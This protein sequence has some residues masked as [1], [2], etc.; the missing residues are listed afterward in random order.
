MA[1]ARQAAAAALL[2]AVLVVPAAGQAPQKQPAVAQAVAWDYHVLQVD[3]WDPKLVARI[4]QASGPEVDLF[5][6]Y[7]APP[8]LRDHDLRAAVPGMPLESLTVDA[9]SIPPLRSGSWWLGVRRA[10]VVSYQLDFHVETTPSS[11]SGMGADPHA[12]GTSFRVWAPFATAV[13]LAGDFNNWSPS[14]APMASEGNGNWSLDVRSVA[15]GARYKYVIEGPAGALWRNDPRA[16]QLTSSSG[17]SVVV[18]PAAFVW[19]QGSYQTPAWNDM[20]VYEMHLGTFRDLPGPA[21]GTLDS[22]RQ[23]LPYLQDLGVNVVELM[24]LVEF[25]GDSSWGYNGSH[26]FAVESAYGDPAALKR[27]VREAHARGI[28]VVL[29][30][31]WNHW[32]PLEMDLWRFDGWSQGP[33]GGIYFYNDWRAQTPWGDT[34]PDFGRGEVR[35]YIRDNALF[36]LQEYRLD[37]L[38]VDST[39]NIRDTGN[40]LGAPLPD[41]WS[42]LQWIN[43][44][45]DASQPWKILFAEDLWQDAWITRPTGAGGAG[46]DSQ[47]CA[48]FVHPIRDALIVANDAQRDMW[49]VKAALEKRYNADAFERTIYTESHDECANGKKRVPEEIWP[50]NADSWA[51]KKRSTMGGAL[52]MTAPGIPMLLQ[53][54]EFLEDGWF[55]DSDP[56]DWQKALTFSGIRQL[57]KDLIALRRDFH[58]TTRGLK[59][60][61]VDVYHVND[62]AKVVA[63]RRWD[64]GGAGDETLVVA[65]FSATPF[66]S[67]LLGVPADGTWRVRLNSDAAVYDPSFGDFPS[68]DVAAL[69][70]GMHGQPY[71]VDLAIGP[72]TVLILSR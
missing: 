49:A 57:Y 3:D 19:N 29:D 38:R 35:Q 10:A 34:R 41:G 51:S 31:V 62:G 6:K 54:Q 16:R 52:V 12:D 61:G 4:L 43:D 22:A 42:L 24:P 17:D 46:F 28:A 48:G 33:W 2:A 56:L 47:W 64:Q 70:G 23:F 53:G 58:G 55:S 30:V 9:Q 40:G 63:F 20:V 15:A 68:V 69:S 65:N 26:P 18:D 50:G 11:R 71:H 1:G 67:Y 27:F 60:Q 21:V 44:E 8:T 66:P 25:P 5:L 14:A 39:V 37:G 36:W 7:G 13:H 72:Y 45:V 32:G 59:G